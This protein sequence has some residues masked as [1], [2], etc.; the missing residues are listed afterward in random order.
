MTALTIRLCDDATMVDVDGEQ[1]VIPLGAV[2]LSS[3]EFSTDPPR[4][5]ELTNAI[6]LVVAIPFTVA[7]VAAG[8]WLLPRVL[9]R[10]TAE[11]QQAAMM[12]L[13]LVP[14][15]TLSTAGLHAL[16][17]VG[18][19]RAWNVLRLVSPLVWL[20]ALIASPAAAQWRSP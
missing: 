8:V 13:L 10:Q 12:C 11:V 6:G 16:R 19:Y 5:E 20:S 1:H 3:T 9:P 4:P 17:G 18:R 2:T 14:L 7:A 15:L